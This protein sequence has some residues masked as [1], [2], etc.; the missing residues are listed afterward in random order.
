MLRLQK[1]ELPVLGYVSSTNV[2]SPLICDYR[3]VDTDDPESYCRALECCISHTRM[4]Y[5]INSRPGSKCEEKLKNF[6]NLK[7]L[8]LICEISDEENKH[9]YRNMLV[10]F[11]NMEDFVYLQE[12][13]VIGSGYPL[14]SEIAVV[15]ATNLKSCTQLQ[16]LGIRDNDIDSES[17]VA[18]ADGLKSCPQ[19]QT[20]GIRDNDIDSESAV[21]LA[22]G[23]KSCTNLQTLHISV[24]SIGSVGTVALAD[25]LKS[26][27]NLQTLHISDNII[28]SE[29]AVALADSLK[30]CT[31]LQTLNIGVNNIDSEGAVALADSLKSCTNLQTL[32]IRMNS[33]G[34]EG[35]V[36]L[37]DGLVL[38]YK[39]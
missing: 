36:A 18:L 19:L 27:T 34:S 4:K 14:W 20:L 30:S 15:L 22:D 37:A 17:A 35:A 39:H 23:L 29:G 21:A 16:T 33:I 6:T 25:G 11:E 5:S 3:G 13:T 38:T 1:K 10:A 8:R 26:C 32:N 9:I 28:G 7:E 2:H 24:N 12:L 31:Y